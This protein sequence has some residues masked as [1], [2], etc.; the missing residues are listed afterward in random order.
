MQPNKLEW[1]S[2]LAEVI[3]LLNDL[4]PYSL[5]PGTADGAPQD[6][7]DT[8][9]SPIAG[10][11]LNSGSVSRSQVDAIWQDW[12]Q[13]EPLLIFATNT[14]EHRRPYT[15]RHSARSRLV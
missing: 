13:E 1:K 8:E 14:N 12:F 15:D 10:M 4:D 7:Y 6:D 2:A 9:A 3:G 11:L 5:A